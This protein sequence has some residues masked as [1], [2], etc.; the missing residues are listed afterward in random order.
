VSTASVQSAT[1]DPNLANNKSVAQAALPAP[2][3]VQSIDPANNKVITVAP[4][5]SK[6]VVT[7]TKQLAGSTV[8][9]QTLTVVGPISGGNGTVTYDPATMTATFT[10][11]GFFD[12]GHYVVTL[13]G[14]G[15]SPI[16]DV[17][18]LALDGNGDGKPGGDFGSVFDISI[19]Q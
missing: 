7:F 3:Q 14:T 1:F 15:G 4:T 2:A 10:P 12:D 9:A 18:G 6:I 17:D 5:P 19:A 13:V 11:N 16:L 8:N